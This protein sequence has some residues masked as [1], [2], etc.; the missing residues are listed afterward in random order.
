MLEP[1]SSRPHWPDAVQDPSKD[2]SGLKPWPWALERL[3]KS[4]NYWISTTRT[5]RFPHL[6]LNL[7]LA[8]GLAVQHQR[9][10]AE[11]FDRRLPL[12]RRENL[13]IGRPLLSA[14]PAHVNVV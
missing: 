7:A 1:K 13:M 12:W 3:E 6:L 4:H 8:I 9:H 2:L 14:M 5:D 11:A 10:L